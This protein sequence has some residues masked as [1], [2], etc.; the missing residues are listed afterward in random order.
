[1]PRKNKSDAQQAAEMRTAEKAALAMDPAPPTP[2]AV[3]PKDLDTLLR[4][5][6]R[7]IQDPAARKLLEAW[8]QEIGNPHDG[9]V[10][11]GA[12]RQGPLDVDSVE[13]EGCP[14]S[15]R[16]CVES[17]DDIWTDFE[18]QI[19]LIGPKGPVGAKRLHRSEH[20]AH[21]TN[22]WPGSYHI[23]ASVAQDYKL[24]HCR[25]AGGESSAD[26][27]STETQVCQDEPLPVLLKAGDH[28]KVELRVSYKERYL[29]VF[30]FRES[31]E[32]DG[33]KGRQMLPGVPITVYRG[34]RQAGCQTTTDAPV[35]QRVEGP[36]PYYVEAPTS[37]RIDNRLFNM[38]NPG[39]ILVLPQHGPFEPTVIPIEYRM[40][41]GVI[42]IAPRLEGLPVAEAAAALTG[43]VAFALF[44]DRDPS[45]VQTA[46]ADGTS[47]ICWDGI[48]E[49]LYKV[50]VKA[51][52]SI[53]LV[54]PRDG[55][56]R[57]YLVPGQE[58]NLS[59]HVL[60]K[61]G[62]ENRNEY[63]GQVMTHSGQPASFRKIELLI[64]ATQATLLTSFTDA[65]GEY[66]FFTDVEAARLAIRV[67]G[68]S[69][70]LL[71]QGAGAV[72]IPAMPSPAAALQEY[73]VMRM[74][75]I[76]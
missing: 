66:S 69:V 43:Q 28:R 50:V 30:A 9:Q 39:R 14:G 44:S 62:P 42:K 7:V 70:Q 17:R 47:E 31:C 3:A 32:A 8:A 55:A 27:E 49:G 13:S 33:P 38:V 16:V 12:G 52:P 56:F 41:D 18:A 11:A 64:A 21:F 67:G 23:F 58:A 53:H 48:P 29:K 63:T 10:L 61:W 71:G 46:T 22:L 57:V 34:N 2:S 37:I 73:P 74:A 36:G 75:D 35:S 72:A 24:D 5:F 65:N 6:A 76:S 45:F 26:D 68:Q 60:F 25:I 4:A 1:M 20:E 40:A 51:G 54:E 59:N 19:F 15:V